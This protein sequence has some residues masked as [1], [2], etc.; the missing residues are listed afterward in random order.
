MNILIVD[1]DLT[2]RLVL[3]AT[4]KML[5]HGVS[6]ARSGAEALAIFENEHVPLIISDMVMA[7]VDGLELC[8]RIRA[9]KRVDYT[10]I[11]LLTSVAGKHGYLVGMR[12]GADDFLAKPVDEDMLSARLHAAERILNLQSQVKQARELPITHKTEDVVW[13]H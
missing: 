4:L 7:D 10:Y 6:V 5:G 12:A 1:D 8:R 11:I 13:I 3:S 9:A 2:S